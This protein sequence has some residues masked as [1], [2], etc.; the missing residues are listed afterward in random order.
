MKLSIIINT[1]PGR[2]ENL[3]A[4]LYQLTQQQQQDFEVLVYDD[5]SSGAEAIADAFKN[6]L[7]LRYFWRPNDMC[8]SRSR[9]LGA[10]E[11]QTD[12]WVFLDSDLLLNPFALTAYMDGFKREPD[13]LW[14]GYFGHARNFI[15]PSQLVKG[16]FVNYLDKRYPVYSRHNVQVLPD[17][18]ANPGKWFWGG[19]MGIPAA[20]YRAL[21]GFNE[22]FIGWGNEDADFAFRALEAGYPIHFNL[23]VWAEHQAHGYQEHFHRQNS[24][25][26]ILN[27]SFLAERTHPVIDYQVKVI[28]S[29][30]L[31]RDLC[32]RILEGYA[33]QD[34]DVPA[35]HKLAF[36]HPQARLLIR[37]TRPHKV[38]M[39]YALPQS[40]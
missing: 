33:Q 22:Q 39:G 4:C 20:I 16:R 24:E 35:E 29:E 32:V 3:R 27:Q 2:E 26:N 8:L 1:A 21:E 38:E 31:A 9:N 34:P 11:A 30:S 28:A 17:L 40:G 6:R 15:A 19:S 7:E 13:A 25:L 37:Q 36:M 18:L 5:G 23:D 12:F 10:A 14:G